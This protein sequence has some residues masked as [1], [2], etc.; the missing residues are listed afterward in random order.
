MNDR[1]VIQKL[2]EIRNA[3][4][5]LTLL[6]YAYV[7]PETSNR[8]NAHKLF[9]AYGEVVKEYYQ[10]SPHF[11]PNNPYKPRDYDKD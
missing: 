5:R 1:E 7:A 9:D 2:E 4:D 11:T 3:V 8:K 6:L 10:R